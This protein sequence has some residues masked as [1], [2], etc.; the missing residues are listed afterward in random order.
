M[1]RLALALAAVL[2]VA[3]LGAAYGQFGGGQTGI[4]GAGPQVGPVGGPQVPGQGPM[5]SPGGG[6]IVP[7]TN[8]R[9][10]NT[11]DFRV[12]NVPDNRAVAP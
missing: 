2:L 12:T 4:P 3:G 11:G 9:I 7:L 5:I 10:T 6:G 8:L 1:R